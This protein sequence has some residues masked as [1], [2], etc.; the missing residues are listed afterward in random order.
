V[1]ILAI[2]AVSPSLAMAEYSV[3]VPDPS[4]CGSWTAERKGGRGNSRQLWVPGFLSGIGSTLTVTK[5]DPLHGTDKEAVWAW[6]D[7]YCQK[8]PLAEISDAALAFEGVHPN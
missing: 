3:L 1:L 2:L 4:S 5:L 7:N 8:N 6:L